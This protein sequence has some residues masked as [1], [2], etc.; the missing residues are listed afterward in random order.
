MDESH[1]STLLSVFL[2]RARCLLSSLLR[3]LPGIYVF[4]RFQSRIKEDE[5]IEESTDEKKIRM[6]PFFLTVIYFVIC[7]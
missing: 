2:K 4:I 3:I 5:N 6:Q 7:L 1:F